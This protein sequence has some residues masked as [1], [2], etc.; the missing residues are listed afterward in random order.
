MDQ[1]VL[2]RARNCHCKKAR[3]M[4]RDEDYGDEEVWYKW[5]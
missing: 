3:K 2:M 5:Q 1:Q 4:K